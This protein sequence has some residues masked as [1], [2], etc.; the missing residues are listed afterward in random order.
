MGAA[1]ACFLL[2]KCYIPVFRKMHFALI[3]PR[4]TNHNKSINQFFNDV[5]EMVWGPKYR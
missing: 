5:E 3:I 2:I 4:P 1:V